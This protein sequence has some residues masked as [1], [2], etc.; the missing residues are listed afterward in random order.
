VHVDED[1]PFLGLFGHV[2]CAHVCTGSAF[3]ALSAVG[4]AGGC[5]WLSL[6]PK[7]LIHSPPKLRARHQND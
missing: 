3:T 1:D 6:A 5:R 4:R 7:N 2:I